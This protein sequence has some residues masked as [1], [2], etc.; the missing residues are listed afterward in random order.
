[1]DFG[2]IE[3]TSR[4]APTVCNSFSTSSH[5]SRLVAGCKRCTRSVGQWI[6]GQTPAFAAEMPAEVKAWQSSGTFWRK[7]AGQACHRIAERARSR[8]H[9][10]DQLQALAGKSFAALFTTFDRS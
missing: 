7:V 4:L 2:F 1:M 5:A 6:R 8:L 9:P 3:M 10:G